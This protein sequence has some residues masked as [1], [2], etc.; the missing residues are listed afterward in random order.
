MADWMTEHLRRQ[1]WLE[2]GWFNSY[3]DNSGRRVEGRFPGGVRMMLTG[4]VFA[5]MSG[6]ATDAQVKRITESARQL[7]VE[8]GHL[9]V[10]RGELLGLPE[11]GNEII[12][13]LM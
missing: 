12:V 13:E 3:Y 2:E 5:V 6:T 11:L 9:L 10:K 8:A 4:Q 1:E 7:P